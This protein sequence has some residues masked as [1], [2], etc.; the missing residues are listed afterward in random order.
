MFNFLSLDNNNNYSLFIYSALFN[1]L[2]D[3]KRITTRYIA[4]TTT[5]TTKLYWL[6]IIT[7]KKAL[8]QLA[9]LFESGSVRRPDPGCCY[10]VLPKLRFDQVQINGGF[11]LPT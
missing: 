3:Q 5:T 7:D 9:E 11:S 1:I 2:G 6:N 4:T 8:P 10:V